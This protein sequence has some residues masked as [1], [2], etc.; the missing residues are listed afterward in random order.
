[1]YLELAGLSTSMNFQPCSRKAFVRTGIP[2]AKHRAV[3]S[4]HAAKAV[5]TGAL[6]VELHHFLNCPH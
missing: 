2:K 4:I 1:M 3:L 6:G 5:V